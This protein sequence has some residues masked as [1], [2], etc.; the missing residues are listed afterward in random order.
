M[1]ILDQRLIPLINILFELDL[2][3]LASELSTSIFHGQELLESEDTLARER[4]WIRSDHSKEFVD[5]PDDIVSGE[6]LL[7]DDQLE[8]AARYLYERFNAKIK[9]ISASLDALDE[10][11]VSGI[12]L[13]TEST[14]KVSAAEAG[15]VSVLL[16]G[17]EGQRID[18]AQLQ[19]AQAQFEILN[20]SLKDWLASIRSDSEQ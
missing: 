5:N 9:E 3:W 18:R 2:G 13:E 7:G 11:V 17:E 19:D 6:P 1:A 16:S 4:E 20:Q 15:A 12:K 8:W 10:I 14:A